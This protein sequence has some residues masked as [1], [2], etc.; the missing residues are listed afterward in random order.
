VIGITRVFGP[1][2]LDLWPSGQ[3]TKLIN[4]KSYAYDCAIVLACDRVRPDPWCCFFVWRPSPNRRRVRRRWWWEGRQQRVTR[5]WSRGS[6]GQGH[7]RCAGR[8]FTMGGDDGDGVRVRWLWIGIHHWRCKEG[9]RGRGGTVRW[10]RWSRRAH[11]TSVILR[12]TS[13]GR[14]P[15]K[16]LGKQR[17]L[18][19][20]YRATGGPNN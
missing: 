3:W 12:K 20:T 8:Q 5:W 2:P 13:C 18:R 15:C 4:S 11:Q 9:Q 16:V 19:S 17:G 6:C 14:R 1:P 10:C 7:R